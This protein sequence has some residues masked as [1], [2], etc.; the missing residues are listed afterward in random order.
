MIPNEHAETPMTITARQRDI[1]GTKATTSEQLLTQISKGLPTAAVI[2]VEKLGFPRNELYSVIGSRTTIQRRMKQ[3]SKL[4]QDE[5]DRLARVAGIVALAEE[6]FGN[7]DKAMRWLQRESVNLAGQGAPFKLLVTGQG[8]DLV[9][10][11]LEQ[12]RHGIYA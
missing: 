5:S 8:A 10:E 6:V 9:R 2:R 1:L 4:A 11:R 12:I 3:K 7:K